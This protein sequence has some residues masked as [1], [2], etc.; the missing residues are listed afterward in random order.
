MRTGRHILRYMKWLPISFIAFISCL[1][2]FHQTQK[3]LQAA[4]FAFF[5]LKILSQFRL[6]NT[7][8]KIYYYMALPRYLKSRAIL[9]KT[10]PMVIVNR[11]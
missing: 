11:Q 6:T 2:L 7:V 4:S 1:V 8:T 5:F 3:S 10:S 9:F